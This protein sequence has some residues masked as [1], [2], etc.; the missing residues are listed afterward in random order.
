MSLAVAAIPEGLPI[1]VTVTLALGVMRMAKRNAIVK[2]LPSVEALGSVG[3]ICADKT[4]TLTTNMMTATKLYTV[5]DG[6]L[7]CAPQES[8]SNTAS[9]RSSPIVSKMFH[10]A[11]LCNNARFEQDAS[12]TG[13]Y[14]GQ[15]TEIALLRLLNHFRPNLSAE[16]SY[17]SHM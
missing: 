12:A 9:I 13:Q 17:Y 6:V 4:G 11:Q 10:C 15:P 1:V 2:R 16:V 14:F 7:E 8:A 3:V 5:G